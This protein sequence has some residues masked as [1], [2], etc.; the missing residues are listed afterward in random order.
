M[1]TLLEEM[2]QR[3][4][5][6]EQIQTCANWLNSYSW[7][8]YATLTFRHPISPRRAWKLFNRWKIALKKHSHNRICYFMVL[9]LDRSNPHL[10]VFLSGTASEK[11][12]L[13]EQ[14]WYGLARITGIAKIKLYNHSLGAS[15]YLSEKW[16]H[17]RAD[18]KFSRELPAKILDVEG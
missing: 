11:P 6:R 14:E 16:I 12:Y 1:L 3:L 8:W 2:E 17:G 15:Y 7:H 18:I 13:W 10:H 5:T 4:L 9:E